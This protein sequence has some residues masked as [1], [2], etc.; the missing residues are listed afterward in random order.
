MRELQIAAPVHPHMRFACRRPP[1]EL[2]RNKP[3]PR[4][5]YVVDDRYGATPPINPAVYAWRRVSGNGMCALTIFTISLTVHPGGDDDLLLLYISRIATYMHMRSFAFSLIC[6][7][8]LLI[9]E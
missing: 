3:Q 7:S 5:Q 9:N 6:L 1:I 4:M 2:G 8:P